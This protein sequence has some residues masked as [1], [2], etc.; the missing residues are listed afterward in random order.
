MNIIL[1]NY[2][3]LFLHR[4]IAQLNNDHHHIFKKM[5]SPNNLDVDIDELIDK[6]DIKKLD[7]A[8]IQIKNSLD[9][10]KIEILY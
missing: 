6:M 4:N 3:R 8:M 9:K 10:L 5:Y 1:E 7:W 2:A